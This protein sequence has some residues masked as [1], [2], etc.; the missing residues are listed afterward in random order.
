[1]NKRLLDFGSFC[2][3]KNFFS[4]SS[5][6]LRYDKKQTLMTITANVHYNNSGKPEKSENIFRQKKLL[7]DYSTT[8]FLPDDDEHSLSSIT[9]NTTHL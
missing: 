2:L 6:N 7:L 9:C 1:M 5:T 8:L 4:Q 3:K